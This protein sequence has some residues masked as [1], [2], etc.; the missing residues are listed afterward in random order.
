V[1]DVADDQGSL[2]PPRGQRGVR[3]HAERPGGG[4]RRSGAGRKLVAGPSVLIWLD[5]AGEY[6]RAAEAAGLASSVDLVTTPLSSD[7]PDAC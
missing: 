7:P 6:L 1:R 4:G 5:D 2:D 3:H